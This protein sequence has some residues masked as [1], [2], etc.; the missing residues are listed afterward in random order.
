MK[1]WAEQPFNLKQLQQVLG[2]PFLITLVAGGTDIT[3]KMRKSPVEQG[4]ILDLS[5]VSEMK[6]RHLDHQGLWIGALCTMT[7][8]AESQEIRHLLPLLSKAAGS[9][10][11]TQIRNRATIG[12]NV[13][14]AAQCADT[15]PV[16]MAL[17]AKADILQ[18]SGERREMLVTELVQ[19]IGKTALKANEV[20]V[21]FQIPSENL[22]CRSGYSKVGSRETVTIAKINCAAVVKTTDGIISSAQVA[23][24]SLGAK[25]FLS[26]AVSLGLLGKTPAQCTEEMVIDLFVS[27]VEEA[28]GGRASLP[29]KRSAV[30]AVAADIRNQIAA[31]VG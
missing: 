31:T 25:A 15:I 28:I 8:L 20:I 14:N 13:G 10:G 12:G 27:Q 6:Q 21:G 4:I 1:L 7:E 26:P 29:Y 5:H 11:S 3:I 24:G 22:R 23:F 2:A 18:A 30:K 9:V 16:L 17:G 19:G